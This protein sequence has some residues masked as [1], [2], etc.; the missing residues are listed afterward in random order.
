MKKILSVLIVILLISSCRSKRATTS[1]RNHKKTTKRV[2]KHKRTSDSTKASTPE[3]AKTKEATEAQKNTIKPN[4][5][6]PKTTYNSSAIDDL[7][8]RKPNL[9]LKKIN[10]IRTYSALAVREMEKFKIPASITLAQGLLESGSGQSYLT[11]SSNNHFGIKCHKWTGK[12]VYH[13]D[14]AKGECF[15]K[16]MYAD[17]SYRDHS[18]FLAS[19]NRY[20]KLFTYASYDY[21]SWAKGLRK[22][23]YATDR[24]YPQKLIKLIEEYELYMFDKFVLGD[25]FK[26]MEKFKEKPILTKKVK[27]KKIRPKFKNKKNPKTHIVKTGETLYAISGLYNIAVNDLIKYNKL[28][29]NDLSIGQKL[30]LFDTSKPIILKT[31]IVKKG[32]TL[33]SISRK[34]QIK[35]QLIK[36]K[37]NLTDN[38]LSIGQVLI[39]E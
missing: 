29:S 2:V 4:I 7:Y 32:D 10:Y 25:N 33:Y 34:Y 28:T 39:I 38:T 17:D 24:R 12:K 23:G 26:T 35:D 11:R 21:Q 20:K 6:A 16:Y 18:L 15:R 27:L 37:N 9:Q 31:H 19:K 22:A 1:K 3:T 14:D 5:E 36:K 30:S 8:R 13:D